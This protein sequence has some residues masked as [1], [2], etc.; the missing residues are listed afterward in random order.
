M[1]ACDDHSVAPGDR[2]A[3]GHPFYDPQSLI[4]EKIVMHFLL[5]VKEYICWGVASFGCGVGVDVYFHGWSLHAWEGPMG[6][7][8]ECGGGVSVE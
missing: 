1:F 6:A 5:P 4:T 3:V 7:G 2:L 8:V